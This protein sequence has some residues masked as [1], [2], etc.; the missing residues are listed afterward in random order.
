[1]WNFSKIFPHNSGK[2]FWDV[3]HW[4][5]KI[6]NQHFGTQIGNASEVNNNPNKFVVKVNCSHFKP[7][8][9]TVKTV[10]NYLIIHGNHEEKTD[11][12]GWVSREFTRRYPL[13]EGVEEDKVVSALH[14]DGLLTIEA[15]KKPVEPINA[16][17]RVVPINYVSGQKAIQSSEHQMFTKPDYMDDIIAS[18][19]FI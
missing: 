10:D 6:Y 16:N 18:Y 14:P 15:P 13:P 12:H 9:I 8:E 1:M 4:P 7:E 17:E 5:Q 2:N 11:G 3:W 19:L